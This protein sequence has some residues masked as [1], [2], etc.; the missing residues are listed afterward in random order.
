MS[1]LVGPYPTCYFVEGCIADRH[2]GACCVFLPSELCNCFFKQL[3]LNSLP[4]D[5]TDLRPGEGAGG[6]EVSL[7]RRRL[8]SP[9]VVS[10][11]GENRNRR[12][13]HLGL[14]VASLNMCCV[15]RA[16]WILTSRSSWRS[17]CR[18]STG[19]CWNFRVSINK[20]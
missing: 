2:Q 14:K 1:F 12:P 17:T 16:A 9:G 13:E 19:R 11:P 6:P 18:I 8:Q 7:S 15:H 5:C 4:S 3:N 10:E 20:Q